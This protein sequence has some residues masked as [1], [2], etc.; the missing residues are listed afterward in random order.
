MTRK[1][2]HD[3]QN[4]NIELLYCAHCMISCL[5]NTANSYYITHIYKFIYVQRKCTG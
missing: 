4:D 5:K 3:T 1:D 2:V